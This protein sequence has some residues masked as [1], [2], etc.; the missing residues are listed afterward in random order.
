MCTVTDVEYDGPWY[1]LTA[2]DAV[3]NPNRTVTEPDSGTTRPD[4]GPGLGDSVDYTKDITAD[5][6]DTNPFRKAIDSKQI[7]VN[8][9]PKLVHFWFASKPCFY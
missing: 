8:T 4:L 6:E 5:G 9:K 1:N 3:Y 2:Y 7:G